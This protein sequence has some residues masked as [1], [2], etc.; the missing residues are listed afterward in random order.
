M[1]TTTEQDDPV[2]ALPREL[3][4]S[5]NSSHLEW[6]VM[7]LRCRAAARTRAPYTTA[8]GREARLE[9]LA[10]IYPMPDGVTRAKIMNRLKV[11]GLVSEQL[12]YVTDRGREFLET[13]DGLNL[14][15]WLRAHADLVR[16]S[17]EPIG[18][19]LSA[20]TSRGPEVRAGV[21]VGLA[22]AM[23]REGYVPGARPSV[24]G[25]AAIAL[26]LHADAGAI[27]DAVNMRLR[28]V[29]R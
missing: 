24:T 14:D 8:T 15:A 23:A 22:A 11:E 9:L 25:L 16:G 10:V 3:G 17:A 1:N 6:I 2:V 28:Q 12:A 7:L 13:H 4:I 29:R 27:V 26:E 20:E 18:D 19:A 21:A 5:P